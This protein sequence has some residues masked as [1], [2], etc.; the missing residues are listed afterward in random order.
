MAVV[1]EK[2]RDITIRAAGVAFHARHRG[3]HPR[4]VFL[5][6]FGGDLH[7]WD[8]L[9]PHLDPGMATL[10]YDLRGYG[11]TEE[12]GEETFSHSEDLLA[13]LDSLNIGRC[14]LVALS[15][16]GGVALRLALDHPGRVASLVLISPGLMAWEWSDEWR[17]QWKAIVAQA[18]AGRLDEA[19]QM[20]WRHPLFD[21]TRD[22]DAASFL[23]DAIMRYAGRQWIRDN[24]AQALPEMERLHQLA[25]RTLLLTGE[26]DLPEF[27][28][29]ADVIEASVEELVRID[30]P[31]LGHLLNL[32]SPAVC[33]RH[34]NGFLADDGR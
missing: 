23:H 16:G 11:R 14:N 12:V 24:S 30:L 31:G 10:R 21:S 25:T 32:E 17:A 19:R 20:W 5:H 33:A 1:T 29:M 27:R 28:L 3:D 18:R 2:E 15:M 9:W 7:T 6:G 26:R 8:L 22:S 34:I 13:I 4:T